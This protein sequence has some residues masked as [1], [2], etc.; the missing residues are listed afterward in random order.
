MFDEITY[1]VSADV[2]Y[3]DGTLAG[4]T[5]P[6]GYA[7]SYP[8]RDAADRAAAWVN[9]TRRAGDFVRA[10]VTGNRYVF[11]SAPLVRVS[12]TPGDYPPVD[13]ADASQDRKAAWLGGYAF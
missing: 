9:A 1:T 8:T 10:A 11:E 5:I 7:V 13:P 12:T 6:D 3:L 4:L 2:R